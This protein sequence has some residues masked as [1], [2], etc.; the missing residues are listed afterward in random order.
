MAEET[1]TTST[2]GRKPKAQVEDTN[3]DVVDL[4]LESKDNND[5]IKKLMAQMAELQKQVENSK[6]EKS[7]MSELIKTLKEGTKNSNDLDELNS[8]KDITVISQTIGKLSLFTEGFGLG[9]EYVFENFG[10][11]LDIPFG[12]LKEIVKNN[13]SFAQKGYF[14]ITDSEAV[15]KLRL[16]ANYQR[17][18]SNEDMMTILEKDADKIMELYDLA[19]EGQKQTIIDLVIEK[20][21]N[22]EKISADVLVA[23]GEKCGKDLINID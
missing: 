14:Y 12:D 7:D 18:L 8:D 9:T 22:K 19:P 4:E 16:K 2:R 10:E 5:M 23:L 17:L 1:K 20:K 6:K 21:L 13:R 15:N 3:K 11:I